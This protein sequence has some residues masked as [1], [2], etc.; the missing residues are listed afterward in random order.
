LG[1]G[2]AALPTPPNHGRVEYL[3]DLVALLPELKALVALGKTARRACALAGLEAIDI[4]HPSPLGLFD[5]GADRRV[6]HREG[7]AR[8]AALAM[9]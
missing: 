9:R 3:T 1:S 5:G 8:A 6:E 2:D 4:C 7:L